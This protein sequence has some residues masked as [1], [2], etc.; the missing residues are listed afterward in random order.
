MDT[1]GG[2]HFDPGLIGP[3]GKLSRL[4]KGSGGDGG[5]KKMM[6]Q[7]ERHFQQQL[8]MM[9]EQAERVSP[10]APKFDPQAA[11]PGQSAA[12]VA[13]AQ[14]QAR[15]DAAKRRGSRQS[16]L[17]GENTLGGKKTLLG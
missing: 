15:R 7:S 4:H 8:A 16:I 13:D 2:P 3:N 11:G 17:A 12:E 1:F 9:R 14:D 10:A 5:M 6:A